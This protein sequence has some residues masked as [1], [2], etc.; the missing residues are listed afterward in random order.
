[1]DQTV[2]EQRAEADGGVDR[3][4]RLC[5]RGRWAPAALDEAAAVARQNHLDWQAVCKVAQAERV[6]P[7]LYKLVRGRGIV[8]AGVEQTLQRAYE[9]T[10]RRNLYRLHELAAILRRL[11]EKG[12]AAIVLK[13]AALAE[14]VYRNIAVRPMSDLDVLVERENVPAAS[15]ALVGLGYEP[16]SFTPQGDVFRHWTEVVLRKPGGG[17]TFVDVHWNLI[18]SAYYQYKIEPGW[19]WETAQPVQ[20]GGARTLVLG[21]EAQILHLCAHLQFHHDGQGLGWLHDIAEVVA[22]YEGRIDWDEVL[23]RAQAYELVAPLQHMLPKV[24]DEWGA[25]IPADVLDRLRGLRLS[26]NEARGIEWLEDQYR[27]VAQ[28]FLA[29]LVGTRGWRARLRCAWDKLFPA[30]AYMQSRYGMPHRVLLPLYYLYRWL[31]GIRSAFRTV[32]GEL[33]RRL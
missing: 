28:Q 18:V 4:L 22:F 29:E 1:M 24:A 11:E 9:L 16:K 25:S 8:P 6:A 31:L 15:E 33:L 7:L 17:D 26:R 32:Q 5:L 20:I 30:P 19:F 21:P 12:I 23:V 2:A 13:G 10:S 3:F 14:V 27:P